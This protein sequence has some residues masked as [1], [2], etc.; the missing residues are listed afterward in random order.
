[1]NPRGCGGLLLAPAAFRSAFGENARPEPAAMPTPAIGRV[2]VHDEKVGAGTTIVVAGAADALWRPVA[3]WPGARPNN[4][5]GRRRR[6]A[7]ITKAVV[8]RSVRAKQPSYPEKLVQSPDQRAP[9]KGGKAGAD[10]HS[11]A[12]STGQIARE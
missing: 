1:M 9:W 8:P 5:A 3:R 11:E 12:L 2:S 7:D 4:R 10:G 6:A